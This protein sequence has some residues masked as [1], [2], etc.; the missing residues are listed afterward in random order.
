MTDR[1]V[2]HLL[3]ELQIGMG[4]DEQAAKQLRRWYVV[5]FE[6][7]AIRRLFRSTLMATHDLAVNLCEDHDEADAVNFAMQTAFMTMFRLGWEA[8]EQFGGRDDRG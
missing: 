6:R 1:D 7:V 8:H 2:I 3:M 4:N 5:R